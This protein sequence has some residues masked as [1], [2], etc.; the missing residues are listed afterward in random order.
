[1][2]ELHMTE[3][4]FEGIDDILPAEPNGELVHWME[5]RPLSV[6]TTGISVTTVVALAVGAVATFAVLAAM[7]RLAPKPEARW[8]RFARRRRL[9]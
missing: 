4:L 3:S 8:H 9:D 2:A 6:G 1:M 5:P 7:H